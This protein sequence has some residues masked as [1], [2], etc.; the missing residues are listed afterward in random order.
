MRTFSAFALLVLPLSAVAGT[1]ASADDVTFEA[2]S[3]L[4]RGTQ[5]SEYFPEDS[6]LAIRFT[7]DMDTEVNVNMIGQSQVAWP[8]GELQNTWTDIK[9]GGA[10]TLLTDAELKADVAV[11]L[12]GFNF[13]YA[14][15]SMDFEWTGTET[16][17]ALLLPDNDINEVSVTIEKTEYN[18][19][20][21]EYEVDYGVF[22]RLSGDVAPRN[23]ATITGT[24]IRSNRRNIE[25]IDDIADIDAPDENDGVLDMESMWYGNSSASFA[26]DVTPTISLCHDWFG[27]YDVPYTYNWHIADDERI[28]KSQNAEYDLFIPAVDFGGNDLDFG[29]VVVGESSTLELTVGA[30][31]SATLTGLA[32]VDDPAFVIEGADIFADA[33][34]DHVIRITFTPDAVGDFD[35]LVSIDT[36]DPASDAHH[37][38]LAG[39][40][41]ELDVNGDPVDDGNGDDRE[42]ADDFG[43]GCGCSSSSS[44]G[45]APFGALFLGLLGLTYRRRQ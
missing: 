38:T 13:N 43:G 14:I 41:Y 12:W 40:G 29:D 4:F 18:V 32:Q 30:M 11:D 6:P 42:T 5:V 33:G 34:S 25:S 22:L 3:K 9:R 27:C 39:A 45:G 37:V 28:I 10:V 16:F 1:D 8:E 26:L 21:E 2:H 36:N 31:S 24:K 19:L 20:Q 23:T 15:W 44:T 35:G 7:A 17:N